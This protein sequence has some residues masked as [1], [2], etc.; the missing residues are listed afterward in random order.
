LFYDQTMEEQPRA[1]GRSKLTP[2]I[3]LIAGTVLMFGAALA[4]GIFIGW[5]IWH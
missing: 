3:P 4:F 1:A 5:L 2:Y